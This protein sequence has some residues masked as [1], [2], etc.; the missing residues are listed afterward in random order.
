MAF[1]S[2]FGTADSTYGNVEY[3]AAPIVI[4][5]SSG[6]QPYIPAFVHIADQGRLHPDEGLDY[7][8]LIVAA[9]DQARARPDEGLDYIPAMVENTPSR[10]ARPDEYT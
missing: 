4:T 5:I 9:I 6:T 10:L 2:I 7:I 8:P 3:A 1:T